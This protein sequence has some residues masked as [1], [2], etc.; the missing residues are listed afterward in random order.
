[1]TRLPQLPPGWQ[2]N[3][4]GHL[5][6]TN[7]R[8][9]IYRAHDG[10]FCVCADRY[11]YFPFNRTAGCFPTEAAALAA[12]LPDLAEQQQQPMTT[13]KESPYK[14]CRKGC[15]RFA[16]EG[17][18]SAKCEG[19]GKVYDCCPD[20]GGVEG[21]KRSLKSHVGLYHPKADR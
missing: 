14:C 12:T 15:R 6:E 10:L 4:L 16:L 13:A 9:A 21:A 19:C 3:S 5:I 11:D 8:R 20:H 7:G 17:T 18:G 1:M 2:R